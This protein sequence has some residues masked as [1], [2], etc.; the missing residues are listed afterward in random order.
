MCIRDRHVDVAQATTFRPGEA[1][2]PG[3][4][5]VTTRSDQRLAR[6]TLAGAYAHAT[7]HHGRWRLTPG[8]RV[9]GYHVAP[10]VS[11]GVIEPR[12]HARVALSDRAALRLG[13]GVAHQAPAHLLDA[14]GVEAAAL[15][16]GLQ[17]VVQVDA[18]ADVLG[19]AGFTFGAGV[20]VQPAV[21]TVTLDARGFDLSLIHI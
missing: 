12:L 20:F 2:E 4:P 7:W 3:R 1:G 5:T 8:L 13:A 18:G 16:L 10:A 15:R 19:P 11:T 9:D 14:P 17:R 6:T 21:R